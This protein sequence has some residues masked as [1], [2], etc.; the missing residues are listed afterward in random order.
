MGSFVGGDNFW[1]VP[2][3]GPS[4]GELASW[5]ITVIAPAVAGAAAW[6]AGR[7]RSIGDIRKVSSR[8]AVR[9]WFW[10]ARPVFVLHLLLVVGALIMARLTVGV[11]PSGAGL[12]AVAHLLVLP[13]G[14]MVIGWVL[15]LL[16]PRAVAALIAA[17]GGWAWL[18]IPRSMS[19][20]TWRHLTGFATE[21]STLTD[22]LDPLVYLVP[23]L[24]TAGLAAAVVLLTGARGRPWLG[25]VSVA[26]LV[27][28]LVT[29]R[30]SV[31]DWGYSPLTDARVG[32]TVCV[33]K[34]PA[35]CLPEEY[36]K[37]AAELRS[38]SVPALEALQAAGVPSPRKLQM[39]SDKLSLKPGTWPLYWSPENS[40]E[41][42]Q[43]DLARSAVTGVAALHGVQGCRQP[44]LAETWALL[45][46]GIDE[47]DVQASVPP[48]DWTLVQRIRQ[49]PAAQQA[50]W[51]TKAA[52]D[53]THCV[54]G[55]T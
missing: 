22:T 39:G 42:Y 43:I 28:T 32:H 12:L 49:L 19:A 13:C 50:D 27:T 7:Q 45:V 14:W 5:G 48:Q 24:V 34:S 21:G 33:G 51:F 4:S 6:E 9:Q 11:W 53:Q 3:Y 2:D 37:N 10:A 35:L 29:G 54:V 38:D 44:Y 16:C 26:V 1:G 46:V 41:Q 8:G 47:R 20:P 17:V 18:A 52:L 31:S 15:G 40:P 55:Q 30:S 23:W 25:A 36:E